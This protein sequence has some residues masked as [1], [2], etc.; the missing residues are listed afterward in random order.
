MMKITLSFTTLPHRLH[1]CREMIDSILNQTMKPDRIIMNL[2]DVSA[3]FPQPYVIPSWFPK[4]IEV[5][6]AG[7]D[8]GPAMKLIPVL[9][10]VTDPSDCIITVDDDVVYDHHLVHDL[11][12]WS[13]NEPKYSAFGC[14]GVTEQ[15]SFVH[16]EQVKVPYRVDI[17]GGY[18]GIL[19]RRKFFSDR[20]F[21]EIEELN[22]NGVFLTDDQLFA[23]HIERNGIGRFVIPIKRLDDIHLNFRFLNLGGGVYEDDGGKKTNSSIEHVRKMFGKTA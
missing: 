2:P 14:M 23:W 19:Y 22:R 4:E 18:R 17:L 6:H 7:R 10:M 12:Y 11:F 9:H 3:R 16:G 8:L 13:E 21:V 15:G 5:F 1:L 20:I